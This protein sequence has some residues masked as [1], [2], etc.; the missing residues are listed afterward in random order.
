MR[1]SSI[2]LQGYKR[3]TDLRINSIPESA[4]LVV[5]IGPNGSGKS[6][7]FDAFLLKS[8]SNRNL[9][10]DGATRDYYQ[11][12][13]FANR[14]LQST[15][16][17]SNDIEI[18]FHSS[19]PTN[20]H[21]MRA[22]YM[23]SAYRNESDFQLQSLDRTRPAV[24]TR[25]FDRII[26]PD[27]AVSDNYRRLAWKRISDMD[28][29][30][31]DDTTFGQYRS[32]SLGK[33]REAMAAL[34]KKP[35]LNLESFGGVQDSG[36]F[37]FSKGAS[38]QFRYSNLS[39]GEK[40]AFDLLLDIFVKRQEYQDAVYCI[41]EPEAH[42]AA[43]LQGPLLDAMLDLLPEKSQMWIATHSIGFVRQASDRMRERGD[44]VFLDFAEHDFDQE[45]EISPRTTDRTFWQETYRIALDDLSELIAPKTI[46]LCEGSKERADKGF[47]AECYN[48]IFSDVRPD[49][50]FVSIGN[51]KQVE[52]SQDLIA[53]LE[54][55]SRGRDPSAH[56]P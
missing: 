22:F 16:E 56:R 18:T 4:R 49:A 8:Q 55:V 40:A 43:A 35:T 27:Q 29:D 52:R 45:V 6:S 19:Q 17:L 36:T 12:L 28:Y 44:V 21:W 24:E 3:F 5:L 32:E 46:I 2:H 42:M 51:N 23:R 31:P 14:A 39:G 26:D 15:H 1:I 30:A 37:L 13:G 33:L 9:R 54:A 41:D 20:E 34:F 48:R 11:K 47:D 38:K 7:L 53:V 25:R 10:L 50:L